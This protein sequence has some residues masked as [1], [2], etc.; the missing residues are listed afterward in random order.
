[1][2]P[3]LVAVSESVIKIKGTAKIH[4][5]TCNEG[6]EGDWRFSSTVS[7]ISALDGMGG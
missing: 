2:C 5:V 3:A 6:T 4:L 1:M 7:L